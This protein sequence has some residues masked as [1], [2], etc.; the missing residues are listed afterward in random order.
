[1]TL[2]EQQDRE[3]QMV[4]SSNR[5]NQRPEGLFEVVAEPERELAPDAG[6]WSLGGGATI[7][8]QKNGSMGELIV[9]VFSMSLSLPRFSFSLFAWS[10]VHQ[11]GTFLVSIEQSYHTFGK[12]PNRQPILGR[13]LFHLALGPYRLALFGLS[14]RSF[15][16]V[17]PLGY[18]QIIMSR[19]FPVTTPPVR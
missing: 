4:V 1:M 11:T 17:W 18:R 3:V 8:E 5:S 16:V 13:V 7:G 10:A 9:G 19:R 14:E 15:R 2:A 6:K 12:R